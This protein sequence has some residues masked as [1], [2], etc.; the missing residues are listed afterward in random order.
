ML[1]ISGAILSGCSD[2][3]SGWDSEG[4]TSQVLTNNT[5]V[6]GRGYY[7]APYHSFYPFPYN[8]YSAGR[9]YYHGGTYTSE[10]NRS[11]ITS[12]SPV[13]STGTSRGGF[14][15]SGFS[16]SSHVSS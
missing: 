15:R 6:A 8:T 4:D 16:H 14:A 9:G 1:V 2:P 11:G 10:P 13:H 5:Y 3:T 7:H 12:S